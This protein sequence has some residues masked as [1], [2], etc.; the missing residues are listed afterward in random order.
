MIRPCGWY[1]LPLDIKRCPSFDIRTVRR[2]FLIEP[3]DPRTSHMKTICI[4]IFTVLLNSSSAQEAQEERDLF[5][6]IE[7][8]VVGDNIVCR[9]ESQFS[10]SVRELSSLGRAASRA[11]TPLKSLTRQKSALQVQISQAKTQLVGLNAQLTNVTSVAANN[12]LVAAIN[13]LDGQID[14]A[15]EKLSAYDKQISAARAEVNRSRESYVESIIECRRLANKLSAA[16]EQGSKNED[17][18]KQIDKLTA[19]AGEPLTFSSSGSFRSSLKRLI[20]YEERI[21][22]NSVP[23]RVEGRSFY[24]SVVING[25]HTEEM[26]VDSGATLISIPHKV[27]ERMG[28]RPQRGDEQIQLVLADGS[29]ISARKSKLQSI[30][31]G[32]Q[33]VQNV[34]CAILGPEAT[35]AEALLGM[36]FLGE[37][38]FSIDSAGS[39]LELTRIE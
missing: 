18:K 38:Q 21:K 32:T 19:E 9:E 6:D 14:L 31:V 8:R 1:R 25:K 17:L 35:N 5:T 33:E 15:T 24:A 22:S 37:F 28:L 7:L 4:L 30:R 16:Y 13:T 23:L 39:T 12:R 27:A 36:S 34:E 20:S 10:K 26:V 2:C 11:I 29:L 3:L